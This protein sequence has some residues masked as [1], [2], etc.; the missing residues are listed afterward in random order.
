MSRHIALHQ[1]LGSV[2]ILKNFTIHRFSG[3]MSRIS[4]ASPPEK[5]FAQAKTIVRMRSTT[6]ACSV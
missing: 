1:L 4:P 5:V 6:C 3:G 2:G